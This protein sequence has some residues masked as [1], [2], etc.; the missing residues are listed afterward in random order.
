MRKC[1]VAIRFILE[2]QIICQKM[3]PKQ[4][5]GIYKKHMMLK[6]LL[7]PTALRGTAG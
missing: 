3:T 5:L 2:L 6:A 4:T 7:V 1:Y